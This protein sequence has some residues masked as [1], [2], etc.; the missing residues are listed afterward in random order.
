ML[1]K[2]K[3]FIHHHHLFY[4]F[5]ILFGFLFYLSYVL[6]EKEDLWDF[7]KTLKNSLASI[8]KVVTPHIV[9]DYQETENL[10]TEEKEEELKNLR[11]LLNLTNLSSFKLE[12]ASVIQ[13]DAMHYFQEI[14]IDKGK[15]DGI[16][17][18]LLAITEKGIVGVVQYVTKNTATIRLLCAEEAIFKI[19][20][21]AYHGDSM[22][23]G[24]V[25]GYEKETGE[26][27]V[28]SIRSQSTVD[29]G[30]VV[31]TSSLS[32]LYPE[33]LTLGAISR[34]ELDEVGVSKI[35]HVKSDVDFK[36]LKYVSIVKGEK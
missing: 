15:E 8:E 32:N 26:I 11:E 24:V 31:K 7:E 6:Y 2:T 5:I 13:R 3:N 22:Y 27:L 28:T 10:F 17:R 1:K 36:N 19:A 9:V 18:G 35:L 25:T 29:I 12:H 4:C 16:D 20:V 21:T 23:N 14:T 30:D 34:I 33:G